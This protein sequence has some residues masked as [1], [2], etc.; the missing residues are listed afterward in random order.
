MRKDGV[1]TLH[2]LKT[3]KKEPRTALESLQGGLP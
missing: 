3:Q 1:R 2:L